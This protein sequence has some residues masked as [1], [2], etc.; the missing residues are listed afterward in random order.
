[1]DDAGRETADYAAWYKEWKDLTDCDA[2]THFEGADYT[3]A[4]DG[5]LGVTDCRNCTTH[6]RQFP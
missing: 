5:A 6:C 2:N 3:A 4:M 1:M